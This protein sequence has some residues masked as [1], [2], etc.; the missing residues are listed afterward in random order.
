MRSKDIQQKRLAIALMF[1]GMSQKGVAE[2]FGMS[3]N[4]VNE[5]CQTTDFEMIRAEMVEFVFRQFKLEKLPI[6]TGE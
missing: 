5:W 4:S 1:S 6:D 3:H 2:Y